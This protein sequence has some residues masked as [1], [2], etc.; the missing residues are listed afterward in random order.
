MYAQLTDEL[1]TGNKTIDSQHQELIDK[2][3]DLL[4]SCETG[5]E[6][7][8]AIRTLDYL[9]DYTDFHFKEEEKLQAEKEYPGI[10]KHKAQHRDFEKTIRELNDMLLEEEGPTQ[11]FVEAVQKNVVDWLYKHIQ[12]FDRSVAEYIYMNTNNERL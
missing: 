10:E 4:R 8:A 11:A 9:A 12:G 6:K 1:L 5:K 3:N 2:I 7:T